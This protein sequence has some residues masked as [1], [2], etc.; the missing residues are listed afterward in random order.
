MYVS[1]LYMYNTRIPKRDVYSCTVAWACILDGPTSVD[2][3]PPGPLYPVEDDAV[4]SQ[5]SADCNPFCTYTWRDP[6]GSDVQTTDGQLSVEEIK[7]DQAGDYT[8][9]ARSEERTL[10]DTFTVVVH[11]PP[12]VSIDVSPDSVVEGQTVTVV[13]TVDSNPSRNDFTW[14]NETNNSDEP[15]GEIDSSDTESIL[16]IQSAP[17]QKQSQIQCSA[18]NS[19][20]G[21]PG[22]EVAELDV[23][24]KDCRA[25]L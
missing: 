7:R 16:T 15:D 8:C 20:P 25:L 1:A 13:C 4:I 18:D 5:C 21:S 12:D 10:T 3:N 6:D 17:C 24:C 14:R 11:Y 9:E 2:L 23:K 22:T 19:V